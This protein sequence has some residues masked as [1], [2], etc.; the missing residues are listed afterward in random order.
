MVG[1]EGSSLIFKM[2]TLIITL[3]CL[4][5][6]TYSEIPQYLEKPI[7]K[8]VAPHLLPNDHLIR[9]SLDQL[10]SSDRVILNLKTLEQAGFKKCKPRKFTRLLVTTHPDFP[11]YIFKLYVDAQKYYKQL[12]EYEYWLMRIHG[13]QLIEQEILRLGLQTHFKVPKKWIYNLPEDPAPPEE[14]LRKNFILVEED[15]SL[16]SDKENAEYWKSDS[17]TQTYLEGLFIILKNIGLHDCVKIDNIPFSKDGKIAFVDT[18]TFHEWPVRYKDL[19]PS[20]S[21]NNQSYWKKLIRDNS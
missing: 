7:W 4:T 11:G 1:M 16:F 6:Q 18:Q 10:F 13:A 8:K 3:C 20:L 2:L 5:F 12:P 17:V 19:T 14:F 15:M 21:P 9:E